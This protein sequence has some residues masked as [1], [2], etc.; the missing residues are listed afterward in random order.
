MEQMV[1]FIVFSFV[2]SITPGPTNLLVLTTSTRYGWRAA[3]PIILGGSAGAAAI[4][5]LTGT[6]LAALLAE[7]PSIQMAISWV[8]V[9]WLSL[10]ALQLFRYTPTIVGEDTAPK[11]R[12]GLIGAAGLQVVNPK[13][14]M[15]A[16]AVVTVF[17]SPGANIG[18]RVLYLSLIFFVVSLPCVSAWAGIGMI[19]AKL[20]N[21]A[22]RMKQFNQLMALLLLASV[23]I[24]QI[25]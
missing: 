20:C 23:W 1:P 25:I 3:T 2:A 12:L 10:I 13:S 8:G 21:S 24:T 9:G 18:Q 17:A 6:G 7:H 11:L 4:V 19:A 14:W 22:T 16:L 15:M 5:F